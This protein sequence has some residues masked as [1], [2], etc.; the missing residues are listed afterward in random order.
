MAQSQRN[1]TDDQKNT[2]ACAG[3]AMLLHM[4]MTL[5]LSVRVSKESGF[6]TGDS[7]FRQ[8]VKQIL[9]FIINT[10]STNGLFA[11]S[12]YSAQTVPTVQ[13]SAVSCTEMDVFT[14]RLRLNSKLKRY[15]DS[16]CSGSAP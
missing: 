2:R 10:Y 9:P 16:F 4:I 5:L 7:M 8:E 11:Q 15:F 13:S 3:V 6:Q 14:H 1:P 12:V